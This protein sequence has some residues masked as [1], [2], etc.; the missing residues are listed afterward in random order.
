MSAKPIF[1]FV[2]TSRNDDHGGDILRRTQSFINRLAEQCERHRVRSE[3][4]LVEWNPPPARASLREVLDWPA[5]TEWF[6]AWIITVPAPLH[7]SLSFSD[8]LNLFQ[9][10]SKNV[11][12]RRAHGDFIIA[13]NVDI[14]FSDELF[15]FLE[16]GSLVEGVVYRADRWDIPNDVQ[17]EPNIDELLVRA[18]CDAIRRHLK[19]GTY[20]KQDGAFTNTTPSQFDAAFFHPFRQRLEILQETMERQSTLTKDAIFKAFDRFRDEIDQLRQDYLI[21]LLHT[22]GCGDFTMLSRRDWF[23]LRGYP[24]WQLFS[25]WIDSSL[26][27]QAYYN[28]LSVQE[29]DSDAVVFHI[30]HDYGSGWTPE[31]SGTLWA[32]LD[33]KRIPYI[34]YEQAMQVIRELQANAEIGRFTV[35]NDL[36]WG[37]FFENDIASSQ[38][39]SKGMPSRRSSRDNSKI[40]PNTSW[41]AADAQPSEY[42]TIPLSGLKPVSPQSVIATLNTRSD[43]KGAAQPAFQSLIL[44]PAQQ[45]AHGAFLQNGA[46]IELGEHTSRLARISV[47]VHIIEGE[48]GIGLLS[49]PEQQVLLERHQIAGYPFTMVCID[50]GH[51]SQI[52]SLFIRNLSNERGAKLLLHKVQ[53]RYK[54]RLRITS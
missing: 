40:P 7:E 47:E 38:V 5:G 43:S 39:V 41:S 14:I 53:L 19:D 26:L 11:G 49:H 46:L 25:W 23:A 24:Q 12:I 17:L 34:R 30:E 33:E 6:C 21:P 52:S 50:V 51:I 22:N 35:Y 13:T 10:I 29:L 31:G 42:R 4:I 37:F 3:L 9:M 28:G 48:V 32:R 27:Y 18:R 44:I 20:V 45:H 54:E 36:D 8:R 16:N 1:S 2:A 15:R